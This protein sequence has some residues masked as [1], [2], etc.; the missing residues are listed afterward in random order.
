MEEKIYEEMKIN[1][2]KNEPRDD[3]MRNDFFG[4]ATGIYSSKVT[5]CAASVEST[6]TLQYRQEK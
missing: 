1:R 2:T 5:S 6:E 3:N 4:V